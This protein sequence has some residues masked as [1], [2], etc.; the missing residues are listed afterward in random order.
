MLYR[1]GVDVI[2]HHCLT[3][4]EAEFFLNEFHSGACGGHLSGLAITQKMLQAGYF[5]LSIFKD[6]VE[7]VKKCHPC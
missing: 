5:W 2:L 4:K 6:C 1:R 7:V 3:H